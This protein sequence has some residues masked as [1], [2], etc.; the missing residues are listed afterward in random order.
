MQ[1]D[2]ISISMLRIDS[3]IGAYEIISLEVTLEVN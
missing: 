1:S 2:E 3:E